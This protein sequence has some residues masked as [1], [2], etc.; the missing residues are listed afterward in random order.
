MESTVGGGEIVP[1]EYYA[2]EAD[3][4]PHWNQTTVHCSALY[5]GKM[6]VYLSY[7]YVDWN[8]IISLD[9]RKCG[10]LK[11]E[12]DGMRGLNGQIL[13]VPIVNVKR[14]TLESTLRCLRSWV[15][16]VRARLREDQCPFTCVKEANWYGFFTLKQVQA[17]PFNHADDDA[18]EYLGLVEDERDIEEEGKLFKWYYGDS[19]EYNSAICDGFK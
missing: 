7:G 15:T 14:L 18:W 4:R 19:Y 9:V 2:M 3:D 16:M 11:R 8:K 6:A 12:V 13:G 1:A 17:L 5:A 10:E